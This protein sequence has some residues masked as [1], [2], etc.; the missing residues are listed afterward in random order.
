MEWAMR[1]RRGRYGGRMGSD[2][3]DY[4]LEMTPYVNSENVL[5]FPAIKANLA[6]REPYQALNEQPG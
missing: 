1:T 3:P 2:N 4:R 6:R 5:H